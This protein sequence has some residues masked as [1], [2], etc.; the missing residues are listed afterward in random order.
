MADLVTTAEYKAINGITTSDLDTVIGLMIDS[1]STM[2][3]RYCGR[4]LTT[5]FEGASRTQ[6]YDGNGYKE[7]QLT[8]W[9]VTSI[10]SVTLVQD[11]G[12]TSA[13]TATDYRVEG[14]TGR[15]RRLGAATGRF[16]SSTWGEVT[17]PGWGWEPGWDDG[18][19]NWSV[20]YTGG[21][22]TIPDDLKW[23]CYRLID[24]MMASRRT[25]PTLQSESIDGY[26]YTRMSMSDDA[27]AKMIRQLLG[28]HMQG[29]L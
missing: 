2:I 22:S 5:G 19:Q 13:L 28:P 17:T 18:F 3:R 29:R 27:D 20:V 16:A 23:A 11:D 25:N 8:E 9:P 26:A 7:L 24:W 10:T 21:Y 14:A 12:S 6:V 4:D 1:A 15:L